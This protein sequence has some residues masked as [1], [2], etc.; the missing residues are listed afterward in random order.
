MDPAPPA[1]KEEFLR[2]ATEKLGTSPIDFREQME[3]IAAAEKPGPGYLAAGVLLLLRYR[4]RPPE[5]EK[6]RICFCPYQ[7]L[8]HGLA[9]GRFELSRRHAPQ[10]ARFPPETAFGR[11]PL[12][13]A[14]G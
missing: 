1:K 9:A 12:A 2:L 5:A 14:H 3:F 8:R 7:T 6:G 11:P 10:E 13:A 4:T